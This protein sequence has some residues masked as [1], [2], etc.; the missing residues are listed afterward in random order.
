MKFF[1]YNVMVLY[2]RNDLME[3]SLI[4]K[5]Q[6]EI[7]GSNKYKNIY[8][9]VYFNQSS[10]GV[11]V[12][13]D[14]GGLPKGGVFGFHIHEGESCTGNMMDPFSEV[15]GHFNPNGK[16]HPAHAGDMPPLFEAGGRAYLSFITDRFKLPD[17]VGKAV[18]IHAKPDDFTTQPSGNSGEKMAC[19]II[20][21]VNKK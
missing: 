10:D 9:K 17:V 20:K 11:L 21:Q 12:T 5:A 13:A 19:G 3:N 4:K 18:I 2:E 6:A 15:G 14:I 16:P 7:F 1:S 8:G